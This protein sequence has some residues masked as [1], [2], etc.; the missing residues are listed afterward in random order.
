MMQKIAEQLHT[1]YQD[2]VSVITTNALF[3]PNKS[4]DVKIAA[5]TE[6]INGIPVTRYD[7]YRGHLKALKAC[8]KLSIRL[9]KKPLPQSLTAYYTGPVSGKMK[10]AILHTD[11]DVIC[12]S[13]VHYLFADY[14]RWRLSIP[15]PKPFVLFGALH[16]HSGLPV[17]AIYLDRIRLADQYI[18]N[19][20]FERD[21]LVEKGI[22]PGKL[23][24]IGT[25]T[26]LYKSGNTGHNHIREK[27]DVNKTDSL[28]LFVGRLEVFKGLPVLVKAFLELMKIDPDVKLVIAGSSGG[29]SDVLQQLVQ[30]CSAIRLMENV[31]EQD[32]ISLLSTA[33]LVVLPSKEESFG[34]VFLEAWCFGKPVI[35]AGTGA[36]QSLIDEGVDGLL[37]EPDDPGDLLD[38]IKRILSD[39]ER[40]RQ[41]GINGYRK[42]LKDF[43]W[44]I[45]AERFRKVYERAIDT[46]RISGR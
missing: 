31:S 7:Y 15:K 30:S 22:D 32:K 14:G 21:Y 46:Y 37:F 45:V 36:I 29:Y 43:T 33:N 16:I 39:P 25:A 20:R 8:N 34:I 24:V 6:C 5:G 40:A 17:Q 28:I 2:K 9:L 44:E 38:K 23:T 19:T 3:G 41:M 10:R 12:A 1:T 11:A 13:T 42:V 35:G 27:L 4:Q 26:D 18:A